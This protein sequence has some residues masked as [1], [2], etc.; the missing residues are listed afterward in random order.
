MENPIIKLEKMAPQP[1]VFSEEQQIWI[2][3]KYGEV[4]SH[5]KSRRFSGQGTAPKQN[6]F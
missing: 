3:F 1:T 6:T 2:I 4:K 5:C